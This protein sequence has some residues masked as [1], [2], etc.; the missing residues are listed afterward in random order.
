MYHFIV[1]AYV[2]KTCHI[3]SQPISACRMLTSSSCF[4]K[5][6]LLSMCRKSDAHLNYNILPHFL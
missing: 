3:I 1:Y 5:S 6:V 4:S 2:T